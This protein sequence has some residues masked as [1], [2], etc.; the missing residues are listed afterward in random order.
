[1]LQGSWAFAEEKTV[2]LP[3]LAKL[4]CVCKCHTSPKWSQPVKASETYNQRLSAHAWDLEGNVLVQRS[5]LKGMGLVACGLCRGVKNEYPLGSG[6]SS[7]A[8]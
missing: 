8:L 5:N 7:P 2:S 4:H 3:F 1:M 6:Q